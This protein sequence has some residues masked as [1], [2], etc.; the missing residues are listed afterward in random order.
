MKRIVYCDLLFIV[1][2]TDSCS[3]RGVCERAYISYQSSTPLVSL[4][5][6]LPK[7]VLQKLRAPFEHYF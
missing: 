4:M 2:R 6:N 3:D 5:L 7:S 1:C